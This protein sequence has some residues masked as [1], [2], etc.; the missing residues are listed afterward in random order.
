MYAIKCVKNFYDAGYEFRRERYLT[1]DTLNIF[2]TKDI[3]KAAIF[4]HKKERFFS[5]W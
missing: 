2:T 3:N 5:S 4:F 1:D